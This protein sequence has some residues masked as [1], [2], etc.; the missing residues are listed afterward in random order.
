MLTNLRK[1]RKAKKI[2][3]TKLAKITNLNLKNIWRWEINMSVMPIEAAIIFA[4]Y[5]D[6]AVTDLIL[7]DSE[8]KVI[9]NRIDESKIVRFKIAN[10]TS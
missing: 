1:L 7:L 3:I 8:Y 5:F 6:C 10:R 4:D 9:S 2:T